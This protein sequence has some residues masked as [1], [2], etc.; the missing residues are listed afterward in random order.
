MSTPSK[1]SN[2]FIYG[3]H[4]VIAAL[5]NPKR[6]NKKLYTT[7]TIW[8]EIQKKIPQSNID[9]NLLEAPQLNKIFQS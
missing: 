7:K 6:H 3:K 4:P 2:I 5:C 9:L 1:K 8:Q